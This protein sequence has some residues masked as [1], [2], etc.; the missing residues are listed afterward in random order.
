MDEIFDLVC[1][2]SLVLYFWVAIVPEVWSWFTKIRHE[3]KCPQCGE[4]WAAVSQ[5]EELIGLF[6][7]TQQVGKA[8]YYG[9]NTKMVQYGKYRLYYKCKACGHEWI[10]YTSRKL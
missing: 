10:S 6:Q 8:S 3:N 4:D 1:V 5:N 7:K 2:G 9:D